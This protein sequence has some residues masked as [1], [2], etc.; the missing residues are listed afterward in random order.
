MK[1]FAM[2]KGKRA[3]SPGIRKSI[4]KKLAKADQQTLWHPFT[5]MEEWLASPPLIIERGKGTW[6]WDIEGNRYLDG[7]SSVWVN[8]HGHRKKELDQAIKN[9]LKKIAHS[10]FLGLSNVPA[11]L[12]ASRLIEIAPKGLT[13][14]FYSD[15]GATAVEIAI[16]MAHQY[17]SHRG[18]KYRSKTK[19]LA[20][21]N[22]YHGDTLGAMSIGG[23]PLFQ[24]AFRP[25]YFA[26]YKAPSPYCYRC[27]VGLE[28]PS[29][30][31][32]CA[33]P[34]EEMLAAHHSEIS[35]VVLE[36]GFQAAGGM[37]PLPPGYLSRVRKLTLKYD[38]LLILDEVATGFGRTGK[39]FASEHESVRPDLMALAKGLTGGYLPLAATLATEEIFSAFLG[40][41]E[42]FKTFFHGHSYT[43]NQLG[44]A[45]ALENLD[46]FEKEKVLEKLQ[47]KIDLM[48]TLLAG[49]Q[50]LSSVGDIRQVGFVGIIELVENKTTRSPFPLKEKK[51]IRVCL[52]ARR[53]GLLIRPLGNILALI[54]PLSTTPGELKRMFAILRK[55]IEAIF[56]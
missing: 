12:L 23:I 5:Q 9:Q 29:C 16:K 3:G 50:E 47:P 32:A 26:T 43:G 7:F 27:P 13:R 11:V 38:V 51:G 4:S 30:K 24:D 44:C 34:M 41:Y 56:P 2:K 8:L 6:L 21:H 39:M 36:P 40:P 28:F 33:A 1:R 31:I 42:S 55:S 20:L 18:G 53:L 37:I 14:V 15:N 19:I 35:A 25:L 17:W 52:E 45:V 49:F 10:T 46:I 22:A 54:P 48:K